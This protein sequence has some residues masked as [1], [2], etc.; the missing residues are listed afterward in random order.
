MLLSIEDWSPLVEVAP[1]QPMAL[2]VIRFALTN[3]AS[4]PD[5][6]RKVME[7]LDDIVSPLLVSFRDSEP[8]PL[9]EC[10]AFL[11]TRLPPEVSI[12]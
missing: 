7:R 10:L 9:L 4:S 8:G 1:M 11:F 5:L 2:D 3:G 6:V 12:P